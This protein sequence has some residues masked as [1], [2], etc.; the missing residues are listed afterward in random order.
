MLVGNI[1]KYIRTADIKNGE[2]QW[3]LT[4]GAICVQ[5][6]S[7]HVNIRSMVL[8]D[9]KSAGAGVVLTRSST[10]QGDHKLTLQV[11]MQNRG[12]ETNIAF[13]LEPAEDLHLN[14]CYAEGFGIQVKSGAAEHNNVLLTGCRFIGNGK[15][16][17]ILFNKPSGT[18]GAT[19]R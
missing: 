18:L 19:C 10:V 6:W 3:H 1:I 16:T 15:A 12:L 2:E 13:D 17:G 11:M 4:R 5:N 8:M 7:K 14:N 9:E